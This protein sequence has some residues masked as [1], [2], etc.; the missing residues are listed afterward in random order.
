MECVL[1]W[2]DDLDD[3]IIRLPLILQSSHT[4]RLLS[5]VF[6][7]ALGGIASI[8]LALPV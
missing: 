7:C 4:Q 6:F 1:Q 2:L 8:L 3:L 5:L